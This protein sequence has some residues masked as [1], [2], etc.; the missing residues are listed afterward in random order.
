MSTSIASASSAIGL[1]DRH[2]ST[3]SIRDS[4]EPILQATG[5]IEKDV[6][7]QETLV[8]EPDMVTVQPAEVTEPVQV[9][10]SKEPVV[11]VKAELELPDKPVSHTESLLDDRRDAIS[12]LLAAL[13]SSNVI[14]PVRAETRLDNVV[15]GD[16]QKDVVFSAPVAR[17]TEIVRTVPRRTPSAPPDSP[18]SILTQDEDEESDEFFDRANLAVSYGQTNHDTLMSDLEDTGPMVAREILPPP[19]R[20]IQI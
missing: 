17:V 19:N 12:G 9:K 6:E 15:A 11:Q 4:P 7:S 13:T 16:E 14:H 18:I 1:L 2:Y 20:Q 8:A 5:W 3:P 10:G